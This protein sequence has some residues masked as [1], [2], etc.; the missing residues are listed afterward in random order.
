MEEF[1]GSGSPTDDVKINSEYYEYEDGILSHAWQFKDFR[2]YPMQ[3]TVNLIRQMMPDRIYNPDQFEVVGQSLRLADMNV[4]K[5]RLP[6]WKVC[7]NV[8]RI[9]CGAARISVIPA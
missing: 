6:S 4:I 5:E 2:K 7:A 3:I 1:H 9:S 8:N